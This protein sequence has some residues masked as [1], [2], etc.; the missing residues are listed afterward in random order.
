[1][2]LKRLE[3][4]VRV[5]ELGSYTKASIVTSTPQP[6]LSRQVRQLEVELNRNLFVRNG[7]GIELTEE[8]ACFLPY[9]RMM[10]S[11]QER[12]LQALRQLN[13]VPAGNVVIGVPPFVGRILT[14]RLVTAFRERFPK[15]TLEIVEGK[16]S[17][18]HE[19][20]LMG[21]SD[22]GV[23]YNPLRS[24]LLSIS[25]LVEKEQFLV[26][27]P[28]KSYSRNACIR[29]RSLADYPLILPSQPNTSRLLIEA[30]AAAAGVQL[31]I[32]LQINGSNLI[33]ELVHQGHGHTILP[34]YIVE[35]SRHADEFRLRRIVNP[36]VATVL[37][38]VISTQRPRSKLLEETAALIC[39]F[40]GKDSEFAR[41]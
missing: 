30:T 34:R 32:P 19:S 14:K 17:S 39:E 21:R 10:L 31:H 8:G 5:A 3:C 40:L 23:W 12:A 13:N 36:T 28:G 11:H 15:A 4:F 27:P 35:E 22:I 38:L 29:F 16:S 37:S 7:R 41:R 25:P 6:T 18:I 1:M 26:S 33:L 9:A 2:D 24:T 20:L